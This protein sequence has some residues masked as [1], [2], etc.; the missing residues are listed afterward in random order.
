MGS[1]SPT[2]S[3]SAEDRELQKEGLSLRA[4]AEVHAESN[5]DETATEDELSTVNKGDV[6]H[7]F[8]DRVVSEVEQNLPPVQPATL[9][10]EEDARLWNKVIEKVML[11]R[12]V[13][14]LEEENKKIRGQLRQQKGENDRG[15]KALK[16][17]K[18][19]GTFRN[20]DDYR[21]VSIRGHEYRL[22]SMQAQV[23][24][25]LHKRYLDSK[26]ELGVDRI[27]AEIEARSSRLRDIFRSRPG[28]WSNLVKKTSRGVVRLNI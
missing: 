8:W 13:K 5:R 11:P 27:L 2:S 10:D 1:D 4:P 15:L 16:R 26:P 12:K 25:I 28:A 19:E 3:K 18:Q 6:T 14:K 23:I 21:W 24:Q 22:T 20:S 7:S 9:T 17:K